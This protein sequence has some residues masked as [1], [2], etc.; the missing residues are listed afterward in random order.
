MLATGTAFLEPHAQGGEE[1]YN[2]GGH[3]NAE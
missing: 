1:E 2:K 3:S